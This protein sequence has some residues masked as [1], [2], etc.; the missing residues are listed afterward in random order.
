MPFSR[1]PEGK[2]LI[3]REERDRFPGFKIVP[4]RRVGLERRVGPPSLGVVVS[5]APC[6]L[7]RYANIIDAPI[8][9]E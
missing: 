3:D 5:L 4:I 1:P 6:S 8:D 7:V 2:A 9:E